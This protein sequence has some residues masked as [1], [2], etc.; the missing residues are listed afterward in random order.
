MCHEFRIS[1]SFMLERSMS[2]FSV[3]NFSSRFTKKL[4]R[5]TILCF[6]KFLV[7]ISFMENRG[8][9]RTEGVSKLSVKIFFVSVLKKF[10]EGPFG[11]SLVSGIGKSYA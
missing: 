3:E 8:R 9:R 2:R 1:K 4:R 11:F 5:G 7:S 6:T 10:V